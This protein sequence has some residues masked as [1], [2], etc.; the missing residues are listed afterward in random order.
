M[1]FSK[2]EMSLGR[3]L[4][5]WSILVTLAGSAHGKMALENAISWFDVTEGIS[6]VAACKIGGHEKAEEERI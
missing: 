5:H 1:D 6:E 3:N 2:G 4:E